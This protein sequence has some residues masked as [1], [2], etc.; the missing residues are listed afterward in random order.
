[1]HER[2]KQL[3]SGNSKLPRTE[4]LTRNIAQQLYCIETQVARYKRF[5]NRV[6][7]ILCIGLTWPSVCVLFICL[8]A[9]FSSVEICYRLYNPKYHG[10]D[11]W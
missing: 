3:G 2:F 10:C 4:T 7:L 11:R 9:P 6:T 8:A 1:M 5:L